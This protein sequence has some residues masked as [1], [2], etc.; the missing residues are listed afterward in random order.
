MIHIN[1]EVARCLLCENALCGGIAGFT[2]EQISPLFEA[3]HD[4]PNVA[5]PDGWRLTIGETPTPNK[6]EMNS[7][8]EF[9]HFYKGEEEPNE[10]LDSIEMA[11]H[12]RPFS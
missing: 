5:L 1:E 12:P 11:R 8:L 10:V 3:A 9:T 6:E 2:D 7:I 4:L